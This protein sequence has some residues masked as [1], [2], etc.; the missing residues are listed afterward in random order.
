[1]LGL[2][3]GSARTEEKSLEI[4]V[5]ASRIPQVIGEAPAAVSAITR[6]DMEKKN[7]QTLDEALRH[8]AGVFVHRRKGIMDTVG[9]PWS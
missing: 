2:L 8:G 4:V 6:E 1:L 7:L 3:L 9:L 5:T